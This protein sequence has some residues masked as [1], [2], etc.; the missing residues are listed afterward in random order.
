MVDFAI[1]RSNL[2]NARKVLDISAKE[3]SEKANLKQVKRIA[4]IEEGR[5]S[6][7]IDE[8]H[9]IC[10]VLKVSVD[11]MLYRNSKVILIFDK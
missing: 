3:L 8:I 9:D 1:F 5:G 2:K 11:D 7:S 4:D 6:P 10:Q